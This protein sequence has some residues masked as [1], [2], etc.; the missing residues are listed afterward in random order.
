M[1]YVLDCNIKATFLNK[2]KKG[3]NLVLEILLDI[4]KYTRLISDVVKLEFQHKPHA[5]TAQ[6]DR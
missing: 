6:A 3:I 2:C 1:T 4:K 5:I